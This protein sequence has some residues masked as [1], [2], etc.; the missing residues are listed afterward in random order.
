MIQLIKTL[1]TI[2]PN[3]KIKTAAALLTAILA[4]VIYYH[5]QKP[6]EPGAK[7][8]QAR[9]NPTAP[10]SQPAS[11]ANTTQPAP[12][13]AANQPPETNTLQP[14]LTALAK[15][16][17]GTDV[18]QSRKILAELR[19]YLD[20]LPPDQAAALITR[21]LADPSNNAP[22]R[23]EYSLNPTGF[24]D[25]HPSLRVALLD[26]LG[27]ID[28]RQAGI[29][30]EKILATPTDADEWSVS[31]RNY[32]RANS[33]A[34]SHAF[35]RAK[36]EEMIRYPAWR[37]NPSIGFFEA[38][39][40]LV[41]TR[42][43]ASTEL[44]SEIVIDRSPEGKPLAHAAFLTLDRLTLREPKVMLEKLTARTDLTQAR[45]EMVANLIARA[46]L[47]EPDQQ[48]LVRNYLLA[49][50]RTAAE[51]SAFAGIYP[52][53]N[54]AISKN[55][56]SENIT[57][58]REEITARDTAALAIVNDWLTDPAFAPVK[59]HLTIMHQRLVIFVSQANE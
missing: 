35:L 13:P 38:F 19:A 28:P 52:N 18:T 3:P 12:P 26:W 56:L 11:I 40:V 10:S 29:V 45:G 51:L 57:Y 22:T 54:F 14:L 41:H 8:S 50:T 16:Q 5:R 32:A 43:T 15:L 34:A 30:A 23:I 49:P 17:T 25:G 55:L 1:Q 9:I 46:D 58:S 24:L 37:K 20:S 7:E 47:R 42:A 59:S 53:A 2:R 44:L 36:T 27:Q 31:L 33:S 6:G 39:D 21:F 4:L 48:Q